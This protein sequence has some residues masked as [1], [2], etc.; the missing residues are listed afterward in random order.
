MR[1]QPRWR[2]TRLH[3]WDQRVDGPWDPVQFLALASPWIRE[4]NA[5]KD[6]STPVFLSTKLIFILLQ[7]WSISVSVKRKK[8]SGFVGAISK[9]GD[10]VVWAPRRLQDINSVI[11]R[12]LARRSPQANL[13]PFSFLPEIVEIVPQYPMSPL[14]PHRCQQ[15][16]CLHFSGCV[17]RWAL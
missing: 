5:R 9:M 14:F 12:S 7:T 2:F 17:L 15:T 1:K 16:P 8:C 11:L 3:F 10:V 13:P 6:F 4:E